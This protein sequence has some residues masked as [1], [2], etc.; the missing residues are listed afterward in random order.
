MIAAHHARAIAASRGGRLVAAHSR[1]RARAE[2]LAQ[3]FGAQVAD[4]LEAL[5]VNPAVVVTDAERRAR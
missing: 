5:V 4:S 1:G 2:K 3:E